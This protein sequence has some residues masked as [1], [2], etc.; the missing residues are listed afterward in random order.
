MN[1]TYEQFS[2]L[3]DEAN[4]NGILLKALWEIEGCPEGK[5]PNDYLA[6][7]IEYVQLASLDKG[8]TV[9]EWIMGD[10]YGSSII[11]TGYYMWMWRRIDRKCRINQQAN[12]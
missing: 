12:F 11:A 10:L 4:G 9:V 5:S 1:L 7:N 6:L 2:Q 3:L 8:H